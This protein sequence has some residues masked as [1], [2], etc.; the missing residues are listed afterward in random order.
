MQNYVSAF[1]G[2]CTSALLFFTIVGLI[3]KTKNKLLSVWLPNTFTSS[4]QSSRKLVLIFHL[5]ITIHTISTLSRLSFPYHSIQTSVVFFAP[6]CRLMERV[7]SA[8]WPTATLFGQF[9]F[10]TTLQPH[11]PIKSDFSSYTGD[12]TIK[13]SQYST[14]FIRRDWFTRR[15]R[16]YQ[17]KFCH[18]VHSLVL[19]NCVCWVR[20]KNSHGEAYCWCLE[21]PPLSFFT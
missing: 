4:N 11:R 20:R 2:Q 19:S 15:M 9:G 10:N 21:R 3:A 5:I 6:N 7:W 17:W 8:D 18:R 13:C 16:N 1:N 12:P 14:T